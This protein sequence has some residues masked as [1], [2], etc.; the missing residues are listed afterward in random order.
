MYDNNKLKISKNKGTSWRKIT[1]PNGVYDYDDINSFIRK[2]IGKLGG[3]ETYG[4]DV[5]YDLTTYK[6]FIKL[7]KNYRIDFKNSGNF[8]DLLGFDKTKILAAS[9]YGTKLPNISNNI[10]NL[11]VRC[12][13]LSE[14]IIS[15]HR[16]NALCIFSTSTK[17]RSLPFE[18]HP[19]NY[20]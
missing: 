4:I 15:G 6:V 2:I 7:D 3:K 20:L 14:S 8:G 1:F 17:T 18:I 10:D 11:Y 5:V 9:A 13:L 16:S 19:R 12:S